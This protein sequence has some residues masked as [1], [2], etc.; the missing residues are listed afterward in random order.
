[1]APAGNI[2]LAMARHARRS[3]PRILEKTA[4]KPGGRRLAQPLN[5]QG[6]DN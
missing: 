2:V 6:L 5:I 1:M 4:Q 3:R